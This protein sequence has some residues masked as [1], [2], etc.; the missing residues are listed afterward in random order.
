MKS[1][2]VKAVYFDCWTVC[3]RTQLLRNFTIKYTVST[4]YTSKMAGVTTVH[5][6]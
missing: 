4:H 6:I 2:C 5:R 1:I 3:K